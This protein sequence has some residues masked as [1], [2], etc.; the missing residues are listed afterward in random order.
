MPEPS[1]PAAPPMPAG[2]CPVSQEKTPPTPLEC[3]TR[4]FAPQGSGDGSKSKHT[5][6]PPR[7]MMVGVSAAL[8]TVAMVR[9]A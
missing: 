9:K 7:P 6:Q 4:F 5:N 3:A 8:P 1:S 2:G